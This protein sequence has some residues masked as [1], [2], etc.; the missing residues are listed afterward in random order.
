MAI[1]PHGN[2][3]GHLQ[4]LVVTHQ[5]QACSDVQL[6]Q[7][8][9][10]HREADAF[11]TLVRRHGRLVWRICNR[12][13]GHHQDAEDAFQATFM[14]LARKAASIRRA[15]ALACWLQGTAQR[16]ALHARRAAAIRR[17]HEQRAMPAQKVLCETVLQ[18]AMAVLD[19]EV[20]HLPP[21]QRAVFILCSL[22]GKSLEEA[23]RVLGW[24]LGTVSGTLARARQAL[25]AKL[26][27]RG[28]T[29]SAMLTAAALVGDSV[30][31]TLPVGLEPATVRAGLNYAAK[32]AGTTATTALA[33]RVLRGMV[34]A[35]G[36]LVLT[37]ALASLVLGAGLITLQAHGTPAAERG[38]GNSQIA[39]GGQAQAQVPRDQ[40]GDALPPGA[41]ARLGTVRLR[42]G[43]RVYSVAQSKDGKLL[44][45]RGLD[46]T[47]R[48][49]EAAS[50]KELHSLPLTST[51]S[52]YT[53]VALAPDGTLLA[54]PDEAPGV[55]GSAV[56]LWD[57]AT[58]KEV[59]RL[60]VAD[61][62]VTAVLFAPTGRLLAAVAQN[63]VH[64]WDPVS[65]QELRQLQ[66]HPCEIERIAFSPD[67][68]ILATG[69]W[70]KTIRLWNPA[71]GE[72]GSRLQGLVPHQ[73]QP[74]NTDLGVPRR[75]HVM[76]LAFSPDGNTLAAAIT[77][78]QAIRLWDTASGQELPRP[79]KDW[80]MGVTGLAFLPNGNTL[81]AGDWDGM[82]RLW[83]WAGGQERRSFRAQNGPIL[84][85]DL[86]AD[87]KTLAASGYVSVRLWD[88]VQGKEL[89]ALAGHDQGVARLAISPDGKTVATA[90]DYY[91]P[92]INLW[93]AATGKATSQVQ[94][95]LG[96]MDLLAF[97]PDGTRLIAG[98]SPLVIADPATGKVVFGSG[99]P[100]VS[101]AALSADGRLACEQVNGEVIAL[102]EVQTAKEVRRLDGY[103]RSFSACV[104]SPDGK[105]LAAAFHTEPRIIVVWE[106]VTGKK[107][108]E[109]RGEDDSA[110]TFMVLAFSP[111]S[112][113]LA[114]GSWN[115]TVRLWEVVTGKERQSFHGHQGAIVTLAFS[116]DGRRLVS[117]GVDA[118]S[119]VWDA[120]GRMP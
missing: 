104:F 56:V 79:L 21:R 62:R 81:V 107:V 84:C 94:G 29:L 65:G 43:G 55:A 118:V 102:R 69:Y 57:R 37:L 115:G 99:M 110:C 27:Q 18:E 16:V 53:T 47:V 6:L 14:V 112:R 71:T 61:D 103:P 89:V 42:H 40:F 77:G 36:R 67:G 95:P 44:A 113:N 38:V 5:T 97:T 78:D 106:V 100:R 111:D 51:G 88:V 96:G 10:A 26:Q 91:D 25:R 60:A 13:L 17:R 23:S 68:K 48:L 22:E 11:A 31:A 54:T 93:D 86:G 28:V 114:S 90:S 105:F 87:G 119:M 58:A 85:L 46:R 35:K 8:F 32:R 63:T 52:W 66:G 39:P 82:V 15:E 73:P 30:A 59:R 9:A 98:K 120:T 74:K 50:G 75:Q 72:E 70:D 33:D 64:L 49:W 116:P 117:G 1:A 19:E 20:Q 24:K 41:V 34:L 80:S 92:T 4:R 12:V 108:W 83:D 101:G 2:A 76:A 7:R 3:L 109:C 45:S